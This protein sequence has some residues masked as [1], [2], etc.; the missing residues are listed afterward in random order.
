MSNGVFWHN[1]YEESPDIDTFERKSGFK[2]TTELTT[3]HK[4]AEEADLKDTI[5]HG[6]K[7]ISLDNIDKI[8]DSDENLVI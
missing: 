4:D 3:T 1:L 5:D 8:N 2:Y 7:N 6:I